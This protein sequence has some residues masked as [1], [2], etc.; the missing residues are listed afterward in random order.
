MRAT[1][2]ID[3]LYAS[4]DA[5]RP[6]GAR[7]DNTVPLG[8][9]LAWERDGLVDSTVYTVQDGEHDHGGTSSGVE[10]GCRDGS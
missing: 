7:C 9:A 1:S 3:R 2:A 6:I 4:R 10:T 5:V 8:L